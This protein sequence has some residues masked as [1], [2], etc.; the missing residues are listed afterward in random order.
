[1]LDS[2][3]KIEL[4]SIWLFGNLIGLESVSE[5]YSPCARLV[6]VEIGFERERAK[7]RAISHES[8]VT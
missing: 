6:T 8:R 1:M 3:Q 5:S 7:A 4:T 2:F